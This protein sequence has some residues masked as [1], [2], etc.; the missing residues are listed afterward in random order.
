LIIGPSALTAGTSLSLSLS[1]SLSPICLRFTL[2]FVSDTAS[3]LL[4]L[5]SDPI[6]Q[7]V[8]VSTL[9]NVKIGA[10]YSR[11]PSKVRSFCLLVGL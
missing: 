2:T 11:A 1:L 5:S 10:A 4:F 3:V 9:L 6:V 8:H 7:E